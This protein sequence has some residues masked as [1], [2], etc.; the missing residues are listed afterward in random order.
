MRIRQLLIIGIF[1]LFSRATAQCVSKPTCAVLGFVNQVDNSE[2]QD[3]R[4]GMGVRALLAQSLSETD[5]FSL[6]EEKPAMKAR[7]EEIAKSTW[8]NEKS[9]A[10]KAT[11][12]MKNAGAEFI[13]C[14]KI[15]HFGKPRKRASFGPAHFARDEVEIKIEVTLSPLNGKK[16]ITAIG[17]GM[18]ATT[19]VTG[20]FTF[21]DE[22]LDADKSMVGIA[23]RKAIDDAVKEVALRYRKEYK[24]V[25]PEKAA[26]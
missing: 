23:T 17:T 24:I 14:G 2:W 20:L 11:A 12:E 16:K 7:I 8:L 3:A 10:D 4:V 9:A 13:A 1:A 21:H 15:F 6:V 19:A 18:A 5:L 26:Q 22:N 25:N